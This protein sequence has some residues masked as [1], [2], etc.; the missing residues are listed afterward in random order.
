LHPIEVRYFQEGGTTQ[1]IV[2]YDGP[3]IAERTIEPSN[4][5]HRKGG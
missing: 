5:V 4:L 3:G 2:T 1:F